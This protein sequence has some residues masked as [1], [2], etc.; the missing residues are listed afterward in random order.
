MIIYFHKMNF[1]N[2]LKHLFTAKR[3][4]L[5]DDCENEQQHHNQ[6]DEEKNEE[7]EKTHHV[8]DMTNV[9]PPPHHVIDIDSPKHSSVLDKTRYHQFRREI[10]DSNMNRRA[11]QIIWHQL[12]KNPHD[13]EYFDMCMRIT[14][15]HL[16]QH[17]LV[18]FFNR[19]SGGG[20]LDIKQHN[21][22]V[23]NPYRPRKI[24]HRE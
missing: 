16:R 6:Y 5:G 24:I 23:K 19:V 13:M 11:T 4:Y 22:T 10:R 17:F 18:Y 14:D 9:V 3:E 7:H 21:K 15:I 8:I 1:Y 12:K 2:T 20:V